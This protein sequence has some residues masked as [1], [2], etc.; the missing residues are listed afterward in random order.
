MIDFMFHNYWKYRTRSEIT[1][2]FIDIESIPRFPIS[3]RIIIF[4]FEFNVWWET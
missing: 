3:F 2:F 1:W 4:N